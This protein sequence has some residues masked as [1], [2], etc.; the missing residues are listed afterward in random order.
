MKHTRLTATLIALPLAAAACGTASTASDAPSKP[1]GSIGSSLLPSARD[2]A[3]TLL[4]KITVPAGATRVAHSPSKALDGVP[5]QESL[6]KKPV[7]MTRW[8][9]V[10]QPVSAV[11]AWLGQHA[12][13]LTADGSGSSGSGGS[14]DTV[15]FRSYDVS[16]ASLPGSMALGD[17]YVAVTSLGANKTAIAAYAVSLGRV[18]RPATEQVPQQNTVV[19]AYRLAPGGTPVRRTLTGPRAA[20]LARAFDA[21]PLAL[22]TDLPCPMQ[23]P[24]NDVTLT[25][26]AD[27]HTWT[28]NVARCPGLGVTRD[29][30]RLPTLSTT[31]AFFA[32]LHSLGVPAS[33]AP[34]GV[35]PLVKTPGAH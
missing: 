12:P 30:T 29:G 34:G 9:T 8:W 17:V 24:D 1:G 16:G 21:L 27:G 6:I 13:Q 23:I 11:Y 18:P 35:T 26:T 3:T 4:D 2:Y 10:D 28:V 22:Q 31:T 15:Q 19:L 14:L 25:F 7:V 5:E 32:E 33:S 20:D